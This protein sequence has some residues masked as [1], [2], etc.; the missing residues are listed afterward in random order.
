[1]TG[2]DQLDE[3]GQGIASAIVLSAAALMSIGLI[4][5]ASASASLD[6]PI[7]R[8]DFWNTT[9]GRQA[10]FAV[11]GFAAMLI[12]AR[13]GVG[14]LRWRSRRWWQPSVWLL[15]VTVGLLAA[16]LVPGIG[17]ESHGARRWLRFGVGGQ[18]LGFQPSELAKL[19]VVLFPAAF[20]AGHA[21][22]VRRFFV[23]LL[24]AVLGIGL[25]AGLVGVED[26]GTAVLLAVVGGLLLLVSGARLR[27]LL[28][29]AV[30]AGGAFVWLLRAEQYRWDRLVAFTK[31]WEDP[32]GSGYHAVQSLIGI[33]S[34][35]WFGRGL[36]GG[37]QKYGYLPESRSDFVFAVWAEET[38]V[39]GCLVVL[40]LFGVLLYCGTRAALAAPGMFER[41][42]AVGVTL[43]I[44][45]QALLNVAVVTVT[46]PTKG[47]ALPLISAGG[48]GMLLYGIAL[49]LLAGVARRGRYRKRG[50]EFVN[51]GSWAAPSVQA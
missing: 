50:R 5:V 33:A 9:V 36:G 40:L 18:E 3:R 28:L 12:L 32:Q 8:A 21:A 42:L 7:L 14:F 2:T 27:H 31:I 35:G 1:M 22:S 46:V 48:S 6:A 11:A 34:G 19:V 23:G 13:T 49:G 25:C 47:I 41:L 24:P 30:P 17:S 4:A 51:E 10:L 43:M 26:F 29:L 20:L 15:I 37:V 44:T 38:G 16:V 39:V 45:L